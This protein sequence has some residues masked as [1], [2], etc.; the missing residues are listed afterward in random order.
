MLLKFRIIFI[1]LVFI[2]VSSCLKLNN[3]SFG[4]KLP[5]EDS[6]FCGSK[7]CLL[8]GSRLLDSAT[9]NKSVT[10]CD[11]FK[12]FSMGKFI[13]YRALHDR[14]DRSGVCILILSALIYDL[15][16]TRIHQQNGRIK[17]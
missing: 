2:N 9:D 1:N 6:E 7:I 12:E 5:T 11:D 10:P 16:G 17:T 14:Y 13:K 8:D 15:D 3:K 4:N